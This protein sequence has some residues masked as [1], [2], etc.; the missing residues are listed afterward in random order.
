MPPDSLD[1][2]SPINTSVPAQSDPC[3]L[4]R[5]KGPEAEYLQRLQEV[6][7]TW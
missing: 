2:I 7:R 4:A 5:A 6:T 1:W 3:H